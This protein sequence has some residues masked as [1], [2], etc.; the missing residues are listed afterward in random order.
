MITLLET[1]RDALQ[2]LPG[3]VPTAEKIALVEAILACDFKVVDFGSFV[4]PK[5]IPQMADSAEVYRAIAPAAAARGTQLLA[6]IAN[7]RGLEDGLALGVRAFGFPLSVSD[8]FQRRNT[9]KSLEET[10]P[11]LIEMGATARA[12]GA[13]FVVYLSMAFG[14]PYNEPFTAGTLTD[15]ARR[16][17]DAGFT[18]LSLADTIGAASPA[19]AGALIGNVRRAL[20]DANLGVHFHARPDRI[21][22][23][24]EAA[25]DSGITWFDCAVG[26][27]GGCPF[28]QDKL[29]GNLATPALVDYLEST[30]HPT[31]VNRV[32]LD[33]ANRLALEIA[34]KYGAGQ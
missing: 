7:G 6:I 34:G 10:W 2:G 23:M 9:N 3:F 1:P 16:C 11:A 33:E 18:D 26:G 31:G 13:R 27:V 20:P 24:A 21:T 28:A 17:A 30:G 32:A 8:T 29:V 19:L 15:A 22:E 14:N 12:A 5:A 4:S 25:L